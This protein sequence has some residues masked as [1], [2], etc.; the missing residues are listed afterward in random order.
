MMYDG[1][2]TTSLDIDT[3]ASEF[4]AFLIICKVLWRNTES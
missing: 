2:D 1:H 3:E 4:V